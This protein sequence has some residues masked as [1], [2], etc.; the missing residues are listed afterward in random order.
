LE[1]RVR[2]HGPFAVCLILAAVGCGR[3]PPTPAVTGVVMIN[4]KP[5]ASA[6]VGFWPVESTPENF[7]YRLATALTD[8][9]GRFRLHRGKGITGIEAGAY[10]VTFSR[11]MQN[12][13]PVLTS[14]GQK[15]EGGGITESIPGPYL[16]PTRLPNSSLS[17][18]RAATLRSTSRSE[19][20][21]PARLA[22]RGSDDDAESVGLY[23]DR[24][25]CGDRDHRPADPAWC[26]RRCAVAR[27]ASYLFGHGAFRSFH[28]GR[29]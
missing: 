26:C 29:G 27:A 28:T 22:G 3:V 11:P 5:A 15:P 6:L 12:G 1:Q 8:A 4:G 10:K 2:R 18:R 17:P 21:Y 19:V 7:I 20:G 9:N 24:T 23:P 25:S 14:A 13:R 16:G